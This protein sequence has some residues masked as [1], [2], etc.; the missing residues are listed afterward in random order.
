MATFTVFQGRKQVGEFFF[1]KGPLVI[2]RHPE[3]DIYINQ[4]V[5]SRRH[6]VIKREGGAWSVE[7]ADGKNGLFINGAFTAFHVLKSGDRIEIGRSVIQFTESAEAQ[8]A[9]RRTEHKAPGGGHYRPMDEVMSMLDGVSDAQGVPSDDP[10]ASMEGAPKARRAAQP[11]P[12]AKKAAPRP[13]A[14][15]ARS[16]VML[17]MDQLEQMH[18]RNT[19]ELSTHLTWFDKANKQMMLQLD[20]PQTILGRGKDV[21]VVIHGG[22]GI[23][24]RFAIITTEEGGV[25]VSRC[26]MLTSVK[27]NGAAIKERARLMDGDKITIHSTTL[28]FRQAML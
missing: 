6:A 20:K 17:S 18:G 5:V 15:D 13:A 2:G 21:D 19:K 7:I 14:E 4:E 16:T 28:V 22:L 9:A 27:V 26:S 23:G 12:A 3:C 8:R 25:Y 10:W 11:L 24:N 1:D